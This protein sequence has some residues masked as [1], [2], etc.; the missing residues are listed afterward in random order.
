MEFRCKLSEVD[1]LIFALVFD[2][3]CYARKE[4]IR[5]YEVHPTEESLGWGRSMVC[6]FDYTVHIPALKLFLRDAVEYDE[7]EHMRQERE[8]SR[9]EGI[10]QVNDLYDKLHDLNREEDIWK[11]IKDVEHRKKLLEEF[12]LD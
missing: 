5:T 11:A 7:E 3:T 1:D 2:Q 6:E 12:H 9:Q 10:E 8:E 4:P